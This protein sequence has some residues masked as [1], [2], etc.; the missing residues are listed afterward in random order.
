MK[1]KTWLLL[2][3]FIV[4]VLPLLAAYFLFAWINA[5]NDEQKVGEHVQVRHE[6]EQVKQ[7]LADPTLY[8]PKADYQHVEQL[9]SEKQ[10]ITLYNADGIILY[11]SNPA[12]SS[13]F[14]L[15]KEQLYGQLYELHQGY[16]TY[17]YKQPVFANND[18]LGFF[19]V[20]MS[21]EEW[22]AGIH[23]R[24]YIVAG[25]FVLVFLLIYMTVVR[26]VNRKLNYRLTGLMSDM[27]AFASGQSVEE[28]RTNPDEIGELTQH[29]YNMKR[30]IDASRKN[31]KQEQQ[32]KEYLIA[33]ISHDLKTPLTSMKAFAES[34]KS[35]ELTE[36]ERKEHQEVIVEK[37]DFMQHML[38]DLLTYTLLQSPSN[39][40]K[41][42]EVDGR[43]F[44]EM[45]VSDYEPM[46]LEKGI[47]LHTEVM[48]TGK[49]RVDPKQM[50]RVTDNL[51]SNAVQHT[52]SGQQIWLAALSATALPTEWLYD[53]AQDEVA[54]LN[55][56]DVYLIV[57]N[58]GRG[59]PENKLPHVFDPI[60]QADEARNKQNRHGTGLGLSITKQIIEKHGGDIQIFSKEHVGTCVICKI[61]VFT[62]EG[63]NN[64][65]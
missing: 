6:L 38:D 47:E 10:S 18:L 24:G 49:F 26:L 42:V 46:C 35:H 34:L 36:K 52:A 50:M 61:P 4:M 37:S 64:E 13:T 44:F 63:E 15:S 29:F 14:S 25:V 55:E 40:M 58:G 17:S 39:K 56:N 43:E 8:E 60:Y 21:R 48:V 19:H 53:F 30:Q 31:L 9:A 62:G 59:I 51:M 1:I 65:H 54:L 20:E 27:T 22:V 23:E 16:R 45:L 3:Y 33:S 12:L 11:A 5:F 2:S 7:V 41:V 28:R 57:Q 32:A